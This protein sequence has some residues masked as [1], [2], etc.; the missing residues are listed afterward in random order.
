MKRYGTVLVFKKHLSKKQI[1][2]SL[3]KIQEILD[4]CSIDKEFKRVPFT[5]NEYDDTLGGPAWY[6]P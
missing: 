2:D 5:V 6:L 4:S 3:K 1:E